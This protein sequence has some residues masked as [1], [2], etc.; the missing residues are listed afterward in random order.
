MIF[1]ETSPTFFR[2]SLY[3]IYAVLYSPAYRKRYEEFLKID[4]PRV[5]LPSSYELFKRLSD[6]GKYLVD[7]HLLKHP[8]LEKTDVGFPKGNSNKVEKVA[9]IEEGQRV[10]INKEQYFEGIPKEV[11]KY[12]IGAYC[13]F[14]S[15]PDTDSV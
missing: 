8:Y 2:N 6:L 9:Y 11:W 7:L 5:P 10:F 1:S 12:R 13:V 14:R 15:I 4:F 3:Y